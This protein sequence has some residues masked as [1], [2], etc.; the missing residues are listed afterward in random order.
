MR[1][2]G[3]RILII[4]LDGAT[5]DL[6][7][8]WVADGALPNLAAAMHAGLWG[9]LRS[10]LPAATFPAWT[11]FMT[12]VN[13]GRHGVFDF[14]ARVPGTYRI[15][16]VNGT[17][18]RVPTLWRMLS[19]AGRRVCSIA[20]PG[21]YPPEPINGIMVSGFDAPVARTIDG[22]FVSPAS[23]YAD[24]LALAGRLPFADVQ[25]VDIGPD[26]PA[27]AV[28]RLL[29]GIARKTALARAWLRR[30]AWDCLSVVF[31]ESDTVAHHCWRYHDRGSP[32]FVDGPYAGAIGRVYRALDAAVGEL[33]AA[34]PAD[35]VRLVVSDH[36]SGGAGDKAIHLNARLRDAGLLAFAPRGAI[37]AAAGAA[38]GVAL[39]WMPPRL[40]EWVFRRAAWAAD[41][42]ESA[43]RFAGIAWAQTVA[44]SEEL[45]YAP[46]VWLNVRGED[47]LGTVAPADVNRATRDVCAALEEWRDP[48]T[49]APIVRRAYPREE[50]YDGPFVH[51]APHVILDLALPDGYSYACVSSVGGARPSIRKLGADEFAGGRGRGLNGTHRRD[52]LFILAGG[53]IPA[54][55]RVDAVGIADLAPTLLAVA[56]IAAPP[57]MDGRTIDR[58]MAAM[59]RPV[60]ME[61]APLAALGDERPYDR[62][63]ERE[64]AAR[65]IALGYLDEPS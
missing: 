26:W 29:D 56:G 45:D 21:T 53:S 3:Q 50:L 42:M 12:G 9:P 37:G 47:P 10:T 27:H 49:G 36:G 52:G 7:R 19:D 65:L 62:D 18:R 15:R 14:T 34:A 17:F 59:P 22:S 23:A 6:V 61:A 11:S 64:V 8:P 54:A 31:G 24:V 60:G 32:R 5:L 1:T 58:V 28:P 20:M 57:W 33:V 55:G 4:G 40:Q 13:P 43:A 51:R 46:S 44:F 39:R 25:E 30:E 16:F 35:T 41:R 48:W 63:E 2:T 38:K